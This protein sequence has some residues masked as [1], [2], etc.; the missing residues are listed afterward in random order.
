[1][2]GGHAQTDLHGCQV[3]LATYHHHK[4]KLRLQCFM[5]LGIYVHK[6]KLFFFLLTW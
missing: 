3:L 4:K 1:M 2:T 5:Y 6:D